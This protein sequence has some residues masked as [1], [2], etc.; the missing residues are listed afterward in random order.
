MKTKWLSEQLTYDGSQLRSLFAYTHYSVLG[1]SLISWRGPCNVKKDYMVDMED[2]LQKSEIQSQDMVH[3]IIE[4][5][6]QPLCVAVAHQRL[7][8]GLIKDV[9]CQFLSDR[10]KSGHSISADLIGFYSKLQRRGDDLYFGDKK[11]NVSIA[12]ASP[13]SSLIHIGVNVSH[14]GT[15]VATMGLNDFQINAYQFSKKIMDGFVEEYISMKK[16]MCKVKWVF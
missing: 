7:F 13:V 2:V 16:A 6:H 15:P 11:I 4:L 9:I 5:F 3:F 8:V 1:D 14:K 10:F 12:T